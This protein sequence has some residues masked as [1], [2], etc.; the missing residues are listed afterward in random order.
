M[1]VIVKELTLGLRR[2]RKDERGV[3]AVVIAVSLLGIVAA[4]VLSV[5]SGNLWTTK[6]SMVQ[7]TDSGA[8]LGARLIGLPTTPSGAGD[9]PDAVK[10]AVLAQ[11]HTNQ[12]NATTP[13]GSWCTISNTVAHR[14]YITVNGQETSQVGFGRVLGVG[15][16]NA[17]SST[18]VRFGVPNSVS[19]L[20]PVSFCKDNPFVQNYLLALNAN[21]FTTPMSGFK[22]SSGAAIAAPVSYNNLPT[23]D[24]NDYEYAPG[25]ND[26]QVHVVAKFDLTKTW[27]NSTLNSASGACGGSSGNWGFVD[28]DPNSNG[29]AGTSTVADWFLTGYQGREIAVN[30]CDPNTSGTQY[31]NLD[32][33]VSGNSLDSGNP[34]TFTQIKGVP[35]AIPI[36]DQIEP[37]ATCSG[38]SN[39][40][41]NTWGFLGVILR[42]W[43]F[44]GNPK[45]IGFE[46]TTIQ[47][48]GTCCSSNAFTGVL[49]TEICSV[50]HDPVAVA[51]RC[52]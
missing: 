43:D 11:M 30:D 49:G 51:T 8:L 10:T 38:G 39:G 35:F 42:D 22:D 28:F 37:K 17:F 7:A 44:S 21:N 24:Q 2:L 23:V 45:W 34:G 41:F 1:R 16:Q 26:G 27:T 50:D 19:G 4:L 31:C 9:C 52:S 12:P 47:T 6:R 18:S 14:G 32:P 3:S 5:D 29:N 25:V 48:S 36:Y 20:R 33:G 40:C 15:D 46:L 13:S